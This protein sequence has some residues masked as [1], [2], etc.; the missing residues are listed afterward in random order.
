MPGDFAGGAGRLVTKHDAADRNF[1]RD[2]AADVARQ[3][4]VVIARD[5]DPVA[6]HLQCRNSFAVA[7]RQALM[8]F[9]VMKTVAERDHAAW[10]MP[11]DYRAEA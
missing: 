1:T 3:R 7:R 5:P 8:R 6:P 10:I 9:A 2:D 4:R 11:C